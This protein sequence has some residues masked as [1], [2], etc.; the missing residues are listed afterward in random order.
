MSH[1]DILMPALSPTMEE[2]TLVRWLIGKGDRVTA[3]AVVAEIETDKATMEIEAADDGILVDILVPD[4][5]EGVKVNTPIARLSGAADDGPPAPAAPQ[6]QAAAARSAEPAAT[7]E[8]ASAPSVASAPAQKVQPAASSARATPLA[9]RLAQQSGVDLSA[10]RGSGPGGLIVKADVVPSAPGRRFEAALPAPTTLAPPVVETRS[11]EQLGVRPGAYDLT[12]RG[13]EWRAA[14]ARMSES[15]RD[16]PHFPLTIDIDLDG[17]LP[18]RERLNQR[19]ERDGVTIS[20]SHMIIKAVAVALRRTP[21]AN[22]SYTPAGI[23]LH[24]DADIA[25]AIAA[26][27]AI[28]SPVLRNAGAKGLAEIARAMKDFED[29]AMARDLRSE[30]YRGASFS[31]TNLGAFGIGSFSAILDAPHACALSVGIA[32]SRAVVRDDAI[33]TATMMTVTLTCDHRAVDG[34]IGASFLGVLR[35]VLQDPLAMII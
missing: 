5:S 16:V 20:V 9:L 19:L 21:A 1:I 22:A 30:D 29:R 6:P 12:P 26:H 7:H 32:E 3:G 17:L 28:V 11:L 34:V 33:R 24:H 27:G 8:S 25:V 18:V 10:L 31:L 14:A 4:G 13:D 23:A 2:G 35:T 15:F